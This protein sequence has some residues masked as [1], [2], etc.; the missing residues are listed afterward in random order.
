MDASPSCNDLS[1]ILSS[2]EQEDISTRHWDIKVEA[3]SNNR[4]V[5]MEKR[6]KCVSFLLGDS[7]H[8]LVS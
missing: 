4:I 2:S 5:R 6:G 1:F 7:V 3:A 8:L